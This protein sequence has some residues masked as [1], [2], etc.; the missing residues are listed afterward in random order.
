MGE[1]CLGTFHN[2][3]CLIVFVF[4]T[5]VAC[6]RNKIADPK[7]DNASVFTEN[8][9]TLSIS[10]LNL[11]ADK[12]STGTI[13]VKIK[14]PLG[15]P[16]NRV[17]VM[18]STNRPQNDEISNLGTEL[19][20]ADG[21]IRFLIKSSGAGTSL[22]TAKN[23]NSNL[24][25]SENLIIKFS[26]GSAA[27]IKINSGN[28]QSGQASTELL[29]PLSVLVTDS[30]DN[31]VENSP[32]DWSISSGGGLLTNASSNTNSIGVA[33]NSYTLGPSSENNLIT[34][35]LR[36]NNTIAVVFTEAAT[37]SAVS[38]NISKVIVNPTQLTA[39]NISTATVTITLND[40][41]GNTV[42]DKQVALSSD[43]GS[44]DTIS[45]TSGTITNSNGIVQFTVK[46][47]KSGIAAFTARNTSD[48]FN[49]AQIPTIEFRGGTPSQIAISSGTNQTGTVSTTLANP[50]VVL[51]KDAN[52]NVVSGATVDWVVTAGGG[53]VSAPT[54]TTNTTGLAQITFTLGSAA[55]ANTLTAKLHNDTT[56]TVNFTAM[57]TA[58]APATA[59]SVS[60]SSS[61]LVASINNLIANNTTTATITVTLKDSR[62]NLI[63]GKTVA[64]TST[65]STSDTIATIGSAT[66]DASGIVKFTV[67]S[68][69]SGSSTYTAT[70]DGITITQKP[71]INYFLLPIISITYP[72]NGLNYST[73][74]KFV[75]LH[76][77]CSAN[78]TITTNLGTIRFNDCNA[79]SNWEAWANL[80]NGANNFIITGQNAVGTSQNTI[81]IT[82]NNPGTDPLATHSW[83]LY[84]TGQTNFAKFGGTIDN[85]LNIQNVYSQN[86]FGD[87]II[88][89]VSDSGLEI[90]HEDLA[91]NI[92]LGSRNYVTAPSAPFLGDPTETRLTS[93]GDHG[94][95]VAGLI[96][97]T[98][99]NNKGSHGVAPNSYLI[100]LNLLSSNQNTSYTLDSLEGDFDIVN[101]SWGYG[102]TSNCTSTATTDDNTTQVGVGSDNLYLT[103]TRD[104][105]L[106]N[107][108]YPARPI[109]YFK[110]AGNYYD[111]P[112]TTKCNENL[113]STFDPTSDIAWITVV[114]A[115]NAKNK[116]SSYSSQGSNIWITGYGGEYGYNTTTLP[117]GDAAMM[118]TD[119]SG[120]TVGYSGTN[121]WNELAATYASLLSWVPAFM[122][123]DFSGPNALNPHAENSNCSYHSQFNGTSAATPTVSG[124]VALILN[125]SRSNNKSLSVRDVKHIL[126][127]TAV[128]IDSL[129]SSWITNHATPTSY[130]FSNKYG[131]GLVDANAAVNMAKTY[132]LS[133]GTANWTSPILQTAN[134]TLS[135]PNNNLSGVD[136]TINV[137]TNIVIEQVIIRV[138]VSHT[139][140]G[141]LGFKLTSPQGTTSL[142]W[143]AKSA[144][145]GTQNLSDFRMLSNAFY[146]EPSNGTWILNIFDAAASNS[147]SITSWSIEIYGH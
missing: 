132:S 115:A 22:I 112:R 101:Q 73:Y 32:V 79:N 107:L 145:N 83:H 147:G 84:N 87:E 136:S 53:S 9:S 1:V 38:A 130:K 129:D 141:D 95:S 93:K 68:N 23:L 57:A 97:A 122:R 140:T 103:T 40:V 144:L 54:S 60:A 39:D 11:I 137:P 94:T 72:N 78:S 90:A 8:H 98:K 42:T 102:P 47:L 119:Q 34:A 35:K 120:C 70:G 29:N 81:N 50:L 116:V 139:Y 63:S 131:F 2:L 92:F 59:N 118:T 20:D 21:N 12:V 117:Y 31:P 41:A 123:M 133:L 4:S 127:L 10:N 58:I 27:K 134:Q 143:D 96:A 69:T 75:I 46:S 49:L 128:K 111:D 25:L 5:F 114:A 109:F 17:K 18:L 71:T 36:N 142:T 85:D 44:L 48:N 121:S 55:G 19:T 16:Q 108:N 61:T 124:V 43:R 7:L 89:A 45:A 66:S 100:G 33:I 15:I 91:N 6:T 104:G 80:A 126:A 110:A 105:A 64:L 52:N 24:I 146:G 56:K 51:V 88:I 14:S 67:K 37:A 76:G 65:R 135:I 106:G 30:Y 138:N 74:K 86:I 3:I 13:Y 77:T 113:P 82:L 62:N 125:A 26:A 28:N 99:N